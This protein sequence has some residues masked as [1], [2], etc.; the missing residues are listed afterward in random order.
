MLVAGAPPAAEGVGGGRA[1][2]TPQHIRMHHRRCCRRH[3][4]QIQMYTPE[5]LRLGRRA[6]VGGMKTVSRCRAWIHWGVTVGAPA[7]VPRPHRLGRRHTLRML[8]PPAALGSGRNRHVQSG[9]LK[10]L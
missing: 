5:R 2:P 7:R 1:A 9:V 10:T 4:C 6:R 3:C 8:L